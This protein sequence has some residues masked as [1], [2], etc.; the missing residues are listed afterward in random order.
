MSTRSEL[1]AIAMRAAQA[2]GDVILAHYDVP[3]CSEAKRDGSPVTAADRAADACIRTIL[4]RETSFPVISEETAASHAVPAGGVFWLVDPLDGTKEFIKGSGEFTVNIA[5]VEGGIPVL[6]VVVA[7]VLRKTWSGCE[8]EGSFLHADEE[9]P[10]QLSVARS[11][12]CVRVAVSRDHIGESERRLIAALAADPAVPAGSSLKF[13]LIA[14]GRADL[15]P[16]FGRTMEWD[17]AAGHCV[18]EQAGG[19]VV[20]VSGERL[21][22]G[23][24]GLE[25]PS[26]LAWG[27]SRALDAALTAGKG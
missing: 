27:C 13:C 26:F 23:K 21:A 12:N 2:A 1:L 5:L 17:T 19:G 10:L 4:E 7:P 18:L 24:S 8:G 25:N 6:G 20:A 14:E 16:R 9:E 15:Y 22:Y 11:G 3:R